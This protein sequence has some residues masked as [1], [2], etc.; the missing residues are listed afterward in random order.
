MEANGRLMRHNRE[1]YDFTAVVGFSEVQW[2]GAR[3][4]REKHRGV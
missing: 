3:C 1:K 4:F 2:E